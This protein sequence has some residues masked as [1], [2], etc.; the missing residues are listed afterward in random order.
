MAKVGSKSP[1]HSVRGRLGSIVYR[2]HGDE[3]IAQSRP[4]RRKG[5]S[6]AQ[7]KGQSRF[8]EAAA[9]ARK[10]LADPLQQRIY[11]ELGS[12]RRQPPNALLISNFLNPPRVDLIEASGYRRKRGDLIKVLATDD[13]EVVGVDVRILTIDS[14]VLEEG[15]ATKQHGVW[16]YTATTDT[17]ARESLTLEATATDRPGH[18]A[19]L[20]I[21]V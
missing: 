16:I 9:Y 14:E 10:V 2:K 5:F 1:V 17:P 11:R 4:D 18:S 12:V 7:K 20:S 15:P 13:I 6:R 8:S 3:T 19:T 21:R